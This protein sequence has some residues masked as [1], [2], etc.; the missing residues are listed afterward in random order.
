[1]EEKKLKKKGQ[2]LNKHTKKKKE[3]PHIGKK[4]RVKKERVEVEVETCLLQL[5]NELWLV[6]CVVSLVV[7]KG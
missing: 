1:M 7:E 5:Y 4:K 6:N 2:S 3:V